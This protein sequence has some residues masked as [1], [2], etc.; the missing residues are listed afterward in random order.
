VFGT[1][2]IVPAVPKVQDGRGIIDFKK[3]LENEIQRL[4]CR[5]AESDIMLSTNK[6][7]TTRGFMKLQKSYEED[8]QRLNSNE[9]G[10][11]NQLTA[12]LINN[13]LT[14]ENIAEQ[15]LKARECY[16]R[17]TK[18]HMQ[19]QQAGVQPGSDEFKKS[20]K[21][22]RDCYAQI[23]YWECIGEEQTGM[24]AASSHEA[25]VAFGRLDPKSKQIDFDA[26]ETKAR[27]AY[28]YAML[29]HQGIVNSGVSTTSEKWKES[30]K[31]LEESLLA[32]QY[33]EG[34]R[35]FVAPPK[36]VKSRPT[37]A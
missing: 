27:D 8:I 2:E 18:A 10:D 6:E 13:V 4:N 21:I 23:E 34:R 16:I 5:L 9:P 33:W 28:L 7:G 12:E 11:A 30:L 17:A 35:E 32:F 37:K 36:F 1:T 25:Q 14:A 29:K 26:E 19:L 3:S 24:S 20:E 31:Q 15:E 22:L